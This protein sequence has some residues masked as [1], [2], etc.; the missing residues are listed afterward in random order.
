MPSA[1]KN[2]QGNMA[3]THTV[4]VMMY[5][6]T[7]RQLRESLRKAENVRP[8]GLV[9]ISTQA[10]RMSIWQNSKYNRK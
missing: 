8:V 5:R 6:L 2:G 7:Q 10:I 3:T 1:A 4:I 9:H